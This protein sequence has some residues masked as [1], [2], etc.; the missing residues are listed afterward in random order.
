M[1]G[2]TG[3]CALFVAVVNTQELVVYRGELV[4]LVSVHVR[5]S[6]LDID[7]FLHFPFDPVRFSAEDLRVS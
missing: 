5:A 4:A 1:C 7:R 3:W 6:L 2:I